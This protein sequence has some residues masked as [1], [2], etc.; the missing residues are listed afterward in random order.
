M[1]LRQKTEL[2]KARARSLKRDLDVKFQNKKKDEDLLRKLKSESA[3]AYLKEQKE[4]DLQERV[5]E[6][7]KIEKNKRS[8]VGRAKKKIKGFDK[9]SKNVRKSFK[10]ITKTNKNYS[11]S[12]SPVSVDNNVLGG[13]VNKDIL[14]FKK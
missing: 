10:K 2:L 4:K 5:I 7:A 13:N 8:F 9:S 3:K 1:K 6:R 11:Y 14:R 12:R